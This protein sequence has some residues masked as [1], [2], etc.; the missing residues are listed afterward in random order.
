M[1]GAV[2]TLTLDQFSQQMHETAGRMAGVSFS[3]PLK[4]CKVLI[5]ADVAQNFRDAHGP[6][7]EPWAPLAHPRPAGGDKPL[8]DKK[9]LMASVTGNAVGHVEELTDT[10]LVIGTNLEYARIHQEGG[11]IT[12]KN[13]KALAIPIT[14]EA[15]NVD[16]P[17]NFPRPLFILHG[18]ATDSACLAESKK[19]RGQKV[20]EVIVHY[21][22]VAR[23]V[24]P[25]RPF[26]GFSQRVIEK[27]MLVFGEF[28]DGLMGGK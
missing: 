8:Q 9:L 25:A 14:R 13:A 23:V 27:M 10:T 1:A 3:K 4:Q 28:I 21:V 18:K 16:G 6:D 24:V 19:S 5:V 11:V 7:G 20:A 26:L 17:R 12:P 15:A 2:Q 22:L